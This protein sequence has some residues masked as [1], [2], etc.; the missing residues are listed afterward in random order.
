MSFFGTIRFDMIKILISIYAICVTYSLWTKR[1][2][3]D[4]AAQQHNCKPAPR[5]R[6]KNRLFGLDI[7]IFLVKADNADRCSEASQQLHKKYGRTFKLKALSDVKL[8]TSKP[9]NI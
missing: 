6:S 7:F 8:Q 3:A 1:A 9:E 5:V 4:K 2:R